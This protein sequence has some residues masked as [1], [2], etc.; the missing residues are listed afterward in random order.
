MTAFNFINSERGDRSILVA[1]WYP[2]IVPEGKSPTRIHTQASPDRGSA[3]YPLVLYSHAWAGARLELAAVL[4]RWSR[5]G[6]SSAG[7]EP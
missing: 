5:T 4:S 2:A 6:L 7:V 3:P 1:V